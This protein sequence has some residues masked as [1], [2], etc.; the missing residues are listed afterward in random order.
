MLSAFPGHVCLHC[1][2]FTV[3][4]YLL[5]SVSG[6]ACM[7]L[8]PCLC[9]CTLSCALAVLFPPGFA[10]TRM[11]SLKTGFAQPLIL[12]GVPSIF[13]VLSGL[14][15]FPSSSTVCALLGCMSP[16]CSSVSNVSS[17]PKTILGLAVICSDW[18][19]GCR[20]FHCSPAVSPFSVTPGVKPGPIFRVC[21]TSDVTCLRF[22]RC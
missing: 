4:L 1:F 14:M 20:A 6:F 2:S 16:C 15:S 11:K 12:S 21:M 13:I 10:I 9:P 18:L 3:V 19:P 17:N 8:A 22:V 7:C 5:G